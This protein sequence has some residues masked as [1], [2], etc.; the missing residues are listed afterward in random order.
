MDRNSAIL[1]LS[2][3]GVAEVEDGIAKAHRQGA[4]RKAE[5]LSAWLE[6][7]LHLYSARIIPV[8]VKVARRIR[9]LADLARGRGTILTRNLRHFAPLEV[10]ALDPFATLPTDR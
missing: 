8:D 2:V 4:S 1:F 10:E 7:V 9:Q 3:L 5:R 6:A